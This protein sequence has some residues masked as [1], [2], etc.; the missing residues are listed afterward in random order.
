[1]KFLLP[2]L[3]LFGATSVAMAQTAAKPSPR[4]SAPAP[5]AQV[6][7]EREL[8]P[9]ELE[10]ASRVYVGRL[11]CELGQTITITPDAKSPGYFDLTTKKM[12]F[13][14]H[15]VQTKSGAV[16]LDAVSSDAAWIQLSNKS[17]LVNAKLGQRMADACTSPEQLLVAQAFEKTPP[18]S[19][20]DEPAPA[21]LPT[22]TVTQTDA[23]QAAG[24]M[25]QSTQ[26]NGE[27]PC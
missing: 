19:L 15:A 22:R 26:L 14:M 20:F 3:M 6:I 8:T 17:M 13:R 9:E 25:P 21:A 2:T 10:V 1:M 16:R 7:P 12:R 5:A 24:P 4:K 11:P 18:P 27:K 23:C